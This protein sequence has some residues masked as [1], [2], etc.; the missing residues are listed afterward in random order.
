MELGDDTRTLRVLRDHATVRVEKG[1]TSPNK[2]QFLTAFE[3]FIRAIN[4][5]NVYEEY[6]YHNRGAAFQAWHALDNLN[7]TV[8][9]ER[10]RY[11]NSVQK[12]K[13]H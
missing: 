1:Y 4:D 2:S 3:S 7:P 8:Q 5:D 13:K 9:E 10:D 6:R 12:S 11:R